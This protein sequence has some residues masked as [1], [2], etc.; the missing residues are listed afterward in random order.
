MNEFTGY[1]SA[2]SIRDFL[3]IQFNRMMIK[4]ADDVTLG[5]LSNFFSFVNGEYSL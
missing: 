4:Y 3:V 5:H 2:M 1:N